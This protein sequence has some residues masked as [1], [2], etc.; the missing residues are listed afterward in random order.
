[1]SNST[2]HG[3]VGRRWCTWFQTIQV[4]RLTADPVYLTP[5]GFIAMTGQG[6]TDSNQS[7]KTTFEA[8]LSLL[9]GDPG[10]RQDSPHFS[11]H[12]I[13][14]LFNPPGVR[15][16]AK[17]RAPVGYIVGV[18]TDEHGNDPLTVWVRIRR[19]DSPAFE[20]VAARGRHLAAGGSQG[21]YVADA[22]RVWSG[23]RGARWG[24]Q[25]YARELYGNGVHCLSFVSTRGQR[26]EQRNTLL[27]SDISQLNPEEIADQ[28]VDLAGMRPLFASEADERGKHRQQAVDVRRM[29]DDVGDAA[30]LVVRLEGEIKIHNGRLDLLASAAAARNR[31]IA[32]TVRH[33][34]DQLQTIAGARQQLQH[35]MENARHEIEACQAQL[36]ELDTAVVEERMA[37]DRATLEAA[38]DTHADATRTASDLAAKRTLASDQLALVRK[39]AERWSGR[40]LSELSAAV[41]TARMNA[42]ETG[43]QAQL[44]QQRHQD[45]A[46]QLAAVQSGEAGPAAERLTEAGISWALLHD[47]VRLDETARARLEPALEPFAGALCITSTDAEAAR[48]AVHDLPG[49]I[50]LHQ[51]APLPP[52]VLSAPPGASALLAALD[53]GANLVGSTVVFHDLGSVTGGFTAPTTGRAAREATAAA[54][55]RRA[56]SSRSTA[57]AQAR[58]AAELVEQLTADTEAARAAV[59]RQ[60]LE[61]QLETLA[62][63]ISQASTELAVLREKLDAANEAYIQSMAVHR[64]LDTQRQAVNQRLSAA[65]NIIKERTARHM[66]QVKAGAAL[67]LPDLLECLPHGDVVSRS[68]R[69]EGSLD[70]Q[71]ETLASIQHLTTVALD[72]A[73][74]VTGSHRDAIN[75]VTTGINAVLSVTTDRSGRTTV[76]VDASHLPAD[77]RTHVAELHQ[78]AQANERSRTVAGEIDEVK[79]LDRAIDALRE[80]IVAQIEQT[81]ATLARANEELDELRIRHE[82]AQDEYTANDAA[83][84]NIQRSIEHQVGGLFRRISRRFNEIRFR[85]GGHGAEL[86][87]QIIPPSFD[88]AV[89]DRPEA[90]RWHLSAVPRWARLAAIDDAPLHVSYKESANTAQYKLATIQ[91]VLA[92]LLADDASAGRMLILDELGDGLGEAHRDLVLDALGRAAEEAGITVMATI[93]DDMQYEAFSRCSEVLLLR[94]R[95]EQDLLNEPTYMYVADTDGLIGDTLRPMTELLTGSR[96]SIWHPL[97]SVYKPA[98]P[99]PSDRDDRHADAAN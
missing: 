45:A 82:S 41:V 32:T 7:S 54:N 72:A 88:H 34:L 24:P 38:R 49:T 11:S 99:N 4:G 13:A 95:S 73:V 89:P 29:A 93:Q 70:L 20:V 15:A 58:A 8:A 43:V 26:S 77:V 17:L 14:L 22:N 96:D 80:Y 63:Q 9:L 75:Q 91:L 44:A 71:A 98:G 5:G 67:K 53:T 28:L 64:S 3:V 85:D 78:R 37:S 62:D 50:L 1:M 55:L 36:G 65:K 30:A 16:A 57:T 90:N 47:A 21:E 23:L 42:V 94:Y 86:E 48:T 83:L 35:D 12:A 61:Q 25:T 51:D 74:N 10:W 87:Y 76:T 79:A 69:D 59:Q 31:T 6:P 46:D 40:E 84:R 81:N 33:T 60:E 97:L 27:G 39:V 66:Q 56:A 92:A 68:A 52:G 18:F 19:H 2:T